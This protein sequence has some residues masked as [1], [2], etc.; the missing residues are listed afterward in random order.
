MIRDRSFNFF[1]KSYI[2]LQISSSSK[3]CC[4]KEMPRSKLEYDQ[5]RY[6][7]DFSGES[8]Y[9][10]N[11][12]RYIHLQ[13]QPFCFC[14]FLGV[15]ISL[16]L[17]FEF[18]HEH[19]QIF[20]VSL[21]TY[22]TSHRGKFKQKSHAYQKMKHNEFGD[23]ERGMLKFPNLCQHTCVALCYYNLKFGLSN[24]TCRNMNKLKCSLREPL[25]KI[26]AS[27]LASFP[28]FER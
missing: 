4:F 11:C 19:L 17:H 25:S 1:S 12:S 3:Q 16:T 9:F 26:V 22:L 24:V 18:I 8:T 23:K 7:P 15:R 10:L 27:N 13:L 21:E 28:L 2:F 6:F 5:C 14:F 20:G